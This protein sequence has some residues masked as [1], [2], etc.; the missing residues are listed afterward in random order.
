MSYWRLCAPEGLRF[1][2][3]VWVDIQVSLDKQPVPSVEVSTPEP[4]PVVVDEPMP[5]PITPTEQLELEFEHMTVSTPPPQLE[6]PLQPE[7]TSNVI[8]MDTPLPVIPEPTTITFTPIPAPTPA[9]VPAPVEEPE[10]VYMSP[11]ESESIHTLVGMG[12]QGD[13]LTV[14]RRNNGDLLAAV[15]ELLGN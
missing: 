2:H 12:F 6:A 4:L 14:L 15:G 10:A 11:Q 3:R 5:A 13:L 9:P 8:I 1:G 7:V